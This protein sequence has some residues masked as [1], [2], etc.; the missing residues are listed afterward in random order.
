MKKNKPRIIILTQE[1]NFFLPQNIYKLSQVAEVLEVNIVD[2]KGTLS[3]KKTDFIR[4]FGIYQVSK[5]AIKLILKKI[6]TFIDNLFGYVLWDGFT[7]V[8]NVSKRNKITYRVIKQVNTES[9]INHVK[10]LSADLIVSY[11]CPIV[12]KKPLL[13]TVKHGIINIHGSYLPYY[14]GLLPSFWVLFNKEKETGATVHYMSEKIDD[15]DIILQEKVNIEN[16]KSIVEVLNKTKKLGGELIVKAVEKIES[17][18]AVPV[19]NDTTKGSYF[20]WP[21]VAEAKLFVKKGGRL[22]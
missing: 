9:F 15:G 13:D 11:S 10:L 6:Q 5:M 7:S 4:W 20:T 12:I 17:N 8:K 2:A 22:I 18:S 3:N 14:R 16:C 21:T 19:K 1:D